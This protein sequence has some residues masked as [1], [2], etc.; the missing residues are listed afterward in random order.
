MIDSKVETPEL[1]SATSHSLSNL[2]I[3]ISFDPTIALQHKRVLY[4]KHNFLHRFHCINTQNDNYYYIY[5][6]KF[7]VLVYKKRAVKKRKI[8]FPQPSYS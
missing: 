3:K 1:K 8:I 5:L 2:S 7:H 6:A 4:I